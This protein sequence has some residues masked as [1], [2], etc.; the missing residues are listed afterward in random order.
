MIRVE[1]RIS[2]EK[3]RLAPKEVSLLFLCGWA[4]T[5]KSSDRGP[6][7]HL[8]PLWPAL[9][10]TQT[11]GLLFELFLHPPHSHQ[12]GGNFFGM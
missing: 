12:T 1:K 7:S 11:P 2:N 8:P 3:S 4:S 6:A 9:S 10:P 5:Q